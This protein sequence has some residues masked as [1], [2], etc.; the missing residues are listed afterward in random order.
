MYRLFISEAVVEEASRGDAEAARKRLEGISDLEELL[1]DEPVLSLTRAILGTGLIPGKSSADA[2]HIALAARHGMDYLLTWNCKHIAN[3]EIVR[4]IS[5][6]ISEC[7]Y[8]VPIIC[9]PRE[10]F[11]GEEDEK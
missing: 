11:G 5:Y 2:L 3:A 8:F 6:V 1:I 9:T 7:G 10:L 4:R